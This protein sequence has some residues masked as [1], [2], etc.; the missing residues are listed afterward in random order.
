MKLD[1]NRRYPYSAI[2]NRPDYN[3]PNGSKLAVYIGLNIEHF[4]FGTGLGAQLVPGHGTGPDVSVSY[5]HLT[6]PTKR[7]V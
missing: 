6:L 7:I 5:T 1:Q 3:W 4:A 2:I